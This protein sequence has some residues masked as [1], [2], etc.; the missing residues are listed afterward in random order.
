MLDILFRLEQDLGVK[1]INSTKS[2]VSSM[3]GTL[4]RILNWSWSK[5]GCGFRDRKHN[6]DWNQ[7]KDMKY[8][9]VFTRIFFPLLYSRAFFYGKSCPWEVSHPVKE[10]PLL[11]EPKMGPP[12]WYFNTR[13]SLG[14]RVTYDELRAW[15]KIVAVQFIPPSEAN[16]SSPMVILRCLH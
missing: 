8:R 10:L 14:R 15:K 11:T 12:A 9:F 3:P 5:F 16:D 6:I 1:K 13:L 7:L 4:Q 2:V